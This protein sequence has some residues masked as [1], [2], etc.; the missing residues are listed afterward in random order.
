VFKTDLG[1]MKIFTKNVSAVFPE[2]S[3]PWLTLFLKIYLKTSLE[4][5]W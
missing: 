2:L 4:M 1:Q 3:A 5:C